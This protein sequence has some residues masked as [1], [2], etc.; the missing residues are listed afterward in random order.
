M[1]TDE[2]LAYLVALSVPVWLLVEQG[3]NW[4]RARRQHDR[5][6]AELAPAVRVAPGDSSAAAHKAA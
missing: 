2:A 3:V 4:L 5:R 1:A 6:R